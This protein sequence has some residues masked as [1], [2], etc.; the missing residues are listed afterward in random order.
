[1]GSPAE[2]A[3]RLQDLKLG[4]RSP[5]AQA[6]CDIDPRP[7]RDDPGQAPP[8]RDR[9][10]RSERVR[11]RPRCRS[12]RSRRP[13]SRRAVAALAKWLTRS[14]NP[15]T[16]RVIV[17]LIWQQHFGTGL[18]ASVS[19]FGRLGE[20]P[21]HPELLDWLAREFVAHGWHFKWLHKQIVVSAAVRQ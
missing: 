13:R 16:T 6:A 1:M 21:S 11:R 9:P 12:S 18:V 4:A 3:R 5:M 19:D 2:G 17:N 7:P 15:I 20:P 8:R 14:D 10:R